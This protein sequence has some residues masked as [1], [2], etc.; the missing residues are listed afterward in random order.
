MTENLKELSKIIGTQR[1]GKEHREKIRKSIK[2]LLSDMSNV[3]KH[4]TALKECRVGVS[5]VL[6]TTSW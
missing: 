4:F 1:D 2:E 5:V 3:A 6:K